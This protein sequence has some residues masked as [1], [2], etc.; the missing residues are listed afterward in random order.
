MQEKEEKKTA[1]KTM[2]KR[3]LQG[4]I[5]CVQANGANPPWDPSRQAQHRPRDRCA[6]TRQMGQANPP[7]TP[8][9]SQV[10]SGASRRALKAT[11]RQP[12]GALWLE[13][14]PPL[15]RANQETTGGVAPMGPQRRGSRPS[16]FATSDGT[17]AIRQPQV[18]PAQDPV[19][20]RRPCHPAQM[21]RCVGRDLL[22]WLRRLWL[23]PQPHP[24]PQKIRRR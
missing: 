19:L 21:M 2:K 3:A 14:T 13:D 1:V 8:C 5:L 6:Q 18:R 24:L 23:R 16:R 7:P 20:I 9:Q 11:S 10:R 15:S 4:H 22:R 17:H 12:R